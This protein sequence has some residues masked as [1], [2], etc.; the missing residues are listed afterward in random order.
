MYI[1]PKRKAP[2]LRGFSLLRFEDVEST[3]RAD[4]GGNSPTCIIH[5]SMLNWKCR[6]YLLCLFPQNTGQKT[7][8][9]PASRHGSQRMRELFFQTERFRATISLRVALTTPLG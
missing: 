9:I 6:V 8:C 5:H 3:Y 7:P 4:V 1:N 2:R